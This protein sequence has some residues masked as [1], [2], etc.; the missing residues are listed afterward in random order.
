[1][2]ESQS[3]LGQTVSHY[4]I[5]E[6]LGGGGMGVVYKAEDIRLGRFVALKFL[7]DDVAH[8]PQALE[9]FKREAR[10]ASA[11]NH[12]NICTIHD[13]GEESGQAFI[14]MEYLE[15]KTLKHT[16]ANRPMEQEILQDVAIEMADA[17]D[18]AHTKGIIHRDIKPANIFVTDRGHAKILD[19]GLAKVSVAKTATGETDVQ[20]TLEVD[21]EHLTSPGAALGTVAYMSPEQA[22]G[23]TL[24]ARTDLFSFG[25][26]LYEMATG[27]LPFRGDTSA[28]SFHSL[29]SKEPISALRLNP[30]L[31]A[32][33]ERIIQKALEKDREVRYQSAAELRADLKRL[34]R[35]TSSGKSTAAAPLP[36]ATRAKSRWVWIVAASAGIVALAGVVA[37]LRPAPPP[38]R[39]LTTTQL[40]HDGF[41]KD[42]LQ[43]DGSRL[44]MTEARVGNFILAQVSATGGETSIIPTPFTNIEIYDV[45]PDRSQ[46]LARGFGGTESEDP[47]WTL[48]LPAGA[49]RRLGEIV[50]H[51]GAWSPDGRKVAF[52]NGSDLFVADA[53]GNNARKLITASGFVTGCRFSPDG[54]RIR[55][56]VN[57]SETNALSLWEVRSDGSDLHALFPGWH[58]PPDEC[59]GRWT[60]DGRYYFFYSQ[61]AIWSLREGK[62]F[63]HGR[64]S[65]P[66]QVATSPL[67]FSAGAASSD[68]KKL[69]VIEGQPRGELVRYDPQSKQFVPFLSGISAGELD[70]SRDAKW[71]TYVTYP[72]RSL[73]RSHVD[74]SDP[75]QLTYPPVRV[76]LPRWSPDGTQIA[77][78]ASRPGKNWR[79]FLISAQGGTPQRLTAEEKDEIDA[80]W[81]PGGVRVAFGRPGPRPDSLIYLVDLKTRQIST[82]PGSENL[83]SPR[84]SPDGQHMAALSTDSTK[85]FLFDFKS[86]KWSEWTHQTASVG[87]PTWSR[88]GGYLYYDSSFTDHPDFGRVKV[89][90]AHRE[91]LVALK[92]LSL[93][94]ADFIGAWTG[95]AP[96][97]SALFVRDLSTQEVYALDLELP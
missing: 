39:V 20:P 76:V 78:A 21:P 29:L 25:T 62:G 81:S 63:F 86:N 73:W 9:R 18:A 58:S 94:G 42:D 77:Y 64:E 6:K 66:M 17:L 8:D 50:G 87:F 15:G 44:Y 95:L 12:P 56:T 11:L 43:T 27:A 80:T 67:N 34:K 52:A 92:G 59:C 30:E 53:G 35:D 96:D 7:P 37:W 70:F 2:A 79:I 85:L 97:G 49:P 83:F 72:E 93:Y 31:P 19:F 16:I 38:P 57:A 88:D 4:R 26:V 51:G 22:L 32:E 69:Y 23:K 71:V 1:M 60:S 91:V 45:S 55:F 13:I 47:L 40:T 68:G 10:A 75:L 65:V 36:P 48:P 82:I 74:G 90:Q 41:F 5:V 33:M 54:S 14:A 24:D 28:A 46:L 61:G 89:G 3:L 84:W